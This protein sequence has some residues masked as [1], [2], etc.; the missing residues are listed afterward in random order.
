MSDD[1]GRPRQLG[2]GLEAL[3]GDSR[4]NLA[5]P[6]TGSAITGNDGAKLP[7]IGGGPGVMR[8]LPISRLIPN[9]S[10]PRR[11][12]DDA[13]LRELTESIR[14]QGI[15]QPLIART[16]PSNEDK[17]EIVAGER[18]WRAAQ[19]AQVHE[20]PVIV[21]EFNDAEAFAVALIENIQRD[22]LSPL[23]EAEAF[24]RLAKDFGKTQEQVA[25]VVGKSR[26]HVA[27]MIRLLDLPDDVR[28]ML[29]DGSL[30]MG[31]A[32]AILR[33][34]DPSEL[35]L[36]IVT[37]GLNVRE[38]ELLGKKSRKKTLGK[39]SRYKRKGLLNKDADTLALER[40][41]SNGLGA[42]VEVTFDGTGGYLRLQY[43]SLEQFEDIVDR[44]MRGRPELDDKSR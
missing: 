19:R 9:P 35:A 33:A 44:L 18:R 30:S 27:N 26:S 15:L 17:F 3:F 37:E 23:E 20:A 7:N 21:R 43:K 39:S 10:Q 24:S 22:E 34:P 8:M 40:E 11:Q 14:E 38:A 13:A 36:K 16:I 25:D 29:Q 1:K 4:A 2:R 31:H 42:K 28:K 12:F 6:A 5:A 41:L 32:R